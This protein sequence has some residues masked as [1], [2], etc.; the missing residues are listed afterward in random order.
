MQL[1]KLYYWC[2]HNPVRA[3]AESTPQTLL[4]RGWGWGGRFVIVHVVIGMVR[5]E[6]FES[7]HAVDARG[8]PITTE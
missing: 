4:I 1:S 5:S 3:S 7:M 8:H 6:L 2:H